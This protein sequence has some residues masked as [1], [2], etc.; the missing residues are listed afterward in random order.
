MSK[1]L[2]G[3]ALGLDVGGTK[4]FVNIARADERGGEP[5]KKFH[6][7]K[8]ANYKSLQ[9]IIAEVKN[10]SGEK[11]TSI[12][13][14][15]AGPVE[16]GK[17]TMT[18]L[19]WPEI[20]EKDIANQLGIKMHSSVR[21][22]N[23]M[24]GQGAS[25]DVLPFDSSN[26]YHFPGTGDFSLGFKSQ[27]KWSFIA[28]GTG[29]GKSD[30]IFEDGGQDRKVMISD[31]EGGHIRW[32]PDPTN[33]LQIQL[34]KYLSTKKSFV[35]QE[36]VLRGSALKA[37]YD[38]FLE[39]FPGDGEPTWLSDTFKRE[40]P[41]A[42]ITNVAKGQYGRAAYNAHCKLAYDMYCSILGS[43][44]GDEAL[45][46][47]GGVVIGGGVFPKIKNGIGETDFMRAYLDRDLP[48]MQNI[49][50][51]KPLIAILNSESGVI[52]ATEMAKPINEGRFEV[53]KS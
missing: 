35:S 33:N 3:R 49:A 10:K 45:R 53:I 34:L 28:P 17:V 41:S 52:G 47:K 24:V 13:A 48:S 7:F 29:F 22:V 39:T 42:I 44:A 9:D 46:I 25:L 36:T 26:V 37:I 19:D 18:N 30:V 43:V 16:N 27:L 31:S 12:C 23:D 11:I 15:I 6:Y 51:S 32:A 2:V 1:L 14:A 5:L 21:V 50:T 8:C 4:A 40:E 20:S 38:F